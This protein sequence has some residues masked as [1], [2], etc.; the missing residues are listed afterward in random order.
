MA[1]I[2]LTIPNADVP[3]TIAALE[4]RFGPRKVTDPGPPVV[5]ETDKVYLCRN[6]GEFIN[7]TVKNEEAKEASSAA[8]ASHVDVSVTCP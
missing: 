3:R 6:F 2:T 1:S 8:E 5:L 7:R 4:K